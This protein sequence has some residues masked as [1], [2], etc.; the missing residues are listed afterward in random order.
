MLQEKKLSFHVQNDESCFG[1]RKY[2]R[3]RVGSGSVWVFG[4]CG[5]QRSGD[6]YMIQV[7]KRDAEKLLPIMQSWCHQSAI[8]NSYWQAVYNGLDQL[9]FEHY[10][11]NHSQNFVNPFTEEHTKRIESLWNTAFIVIKLILIIFFPHPIIQK[12]NLLIITISR[13]IF[14]ITFNMS[15]QRTH[16]ATMA[17]KPNC[18]NK[19]KSDI[20]RNSCIFLLQW[21]WLLNY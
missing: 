4:A 1:K 19:K 15:S 9:G 18:Q 7:V 5:A 3:G 11:V 8:I 14:D 13:P 21:C 2:N 20:K 6:V 10:T 16:S 17:H 12:L